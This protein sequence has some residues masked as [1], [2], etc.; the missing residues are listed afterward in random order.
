MDTRFV[1]ISEAGLLL[2]VI[3]HSLN[4]VRLTLLDIGTPTKYQKLLFRTAAVMGGIIFLF[5]A[6]P[7]MGGGH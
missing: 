3:V 4:G 5:S 2:L 6:W 1:K 7:I